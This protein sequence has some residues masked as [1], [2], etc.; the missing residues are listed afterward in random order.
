MR[1]EMS[2]QEHGWKRED[3]N[4]TSPHD[5]HNYLTQVDDPIHMKFSACFRANDTRREKAVY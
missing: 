4:R 5:H 1:C 3:L 2:R